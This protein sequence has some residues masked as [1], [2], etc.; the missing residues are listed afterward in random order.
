M[1]QRIDS[2]KKLLSED[3]DAI[4]V[5]CGAPRGR[6][7]DIPGRKEAGAN[8]HIGIDWLSCVSFGHTTSIGKRVIVLGGGNTAMDCCR[9]SRRLGGEDVNVIVRSGFEEMKASPWEKEDAM[10]EGIPIHNFLVPKEFMHENGKLTG[11]SF[12]KVKADYDAKGRRTLVP[13]GEPD[14]HHR[15]RRRAGRGRPGE[16]LPLDR[17]RYRHRIRQMGH[18]GGRSGDHAIDHSERVL[19]RRRGVRPQEHHLG[20][21]AWP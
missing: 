19:R 16:R 11:V 12:E 3:Y 2:L 4:F 1:G 7:L 17:A 5:G 14:Q 8:I 10:H 21:G 15:V 9:T 13:T 6:E 20:G 18:A